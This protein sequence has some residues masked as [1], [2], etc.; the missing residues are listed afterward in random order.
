MEQL[1]YDVAQNLTA[2]SQ[3]L[4]VVPATNDRPGTCNWQLVDRLLAESDHS[5]TRTTPS[6][7]AA[8]WPTNPCDILLKAPGNTGGYLHFLWLLY[9]SALERSEPG[10][11]HPPARL[12]TSADVAMGICSVTFSLTYFSIMPVR[13]FITIMYFH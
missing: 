2:S 9:V 3:N 7:L 1:S 6:S 4:L 5:S 10:L 12:K 13:F 8:F 11:Q